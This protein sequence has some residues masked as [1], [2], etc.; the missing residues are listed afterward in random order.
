[1]IVS[2]RPTPPASRPWSSA[3]WPSDAETWVWEISFRSIGSAPMRRLSAR[4]WVSCGE[5]MPLIWAPVRP[6]M[7]SGF[8][9]KS[10]VASET[11]LLSSVIAKRWSAA[12]RSEPGGRMISDP[13]WAIRL[14]TRAK[15]S[16][17]LSV[18]SIVTMGSWVCWSKFC[19]GFLMSV[20]DS[21]ES[22]S[23]TK[24]RCTDS[25][26]FSARSASTT[27]MPCGTLSTSL[28]AGGPL[29]NGGSGSLSSPACPTGIA[30]SASAHSL[31]FGTSSAPR[32]GP[33]IDSK[34]TSSSSQVV[35]GPLISR[36]SGPNR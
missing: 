20:P 9:R 16:R 22:S 28:S 4:S 34:S 5:P 1:M 31:A 8:S 11:I 23:S 29:R 35:A 13:R 6:S 7:P 18:N 36:W 14:V 3:C 15:A 21:S 32:G 12:S 33:R 30:A 2:S 17:P 27:T 26:W 25:G 10:I 24:K 19:S